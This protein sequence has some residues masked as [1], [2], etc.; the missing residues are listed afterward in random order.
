MN[1][2]CNTGTCPILLDGQCVFYEGAALPFSDINTN[3]NLQTVIQKLDAKMATISGGTGVTSVGVVAGVGIA[4]SV[5]NPTT[6]PVITITNLAPDQLV[7]LTPGANISVSGVYP[8]FTIAATFTESVF[9]NDV[10]FVLSS[11]K[12]FGKYTNGQTA[13]WTGLTA[14]EAIE[15]A[16]IEYI[17]PVFTSFSVTGQST[18]VEVGT[19]LSGSKTFTWAITLNSGVVPTI[20]LYDVTAGATLLAGTANDGTQAQ[21]V[22][23]LQLNADG[24]TQAWRGIG[25][26]TSPAGTFNSSNFT[27]TSR[28]YR[29]YGPSASTPANSAAVRALSTSAFQ[30][31][32]VNTFQLNTGT[33]QTKF[34]VALPPGRTITQVLD[35][36]ALYANITAN[37]VLLGT[38]SVLD[39]GGTSRTYNLYEMNIG[40]PYASN[41]RHEITTA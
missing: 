12:S 39:A 13:A 26:N 36:D 16:A 31:S 30:T 14:V 37:Y 34:V 5:A 20:D 3:D 9:A 27:V 19:T 11:G 33:T 7:T 40:A 22:T 8:N 15:D 10:T 1:V 41:H 6:T 24:S 21:V 4:A 25:N 32:A 17:N 2:V 29:F 38:I 35:V 23:T 28:Y 18:T